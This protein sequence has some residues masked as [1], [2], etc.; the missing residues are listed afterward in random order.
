MGYATFWRPLASGMH[1]SH[2][3]HHVWL[4]L[5]NEPVTRMGNDLAR[6]RDST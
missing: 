5:I 6:S 2:N 4:K 1:Q 3:P